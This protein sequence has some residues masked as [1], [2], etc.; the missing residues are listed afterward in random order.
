MSAALWF[1]VGVIAMQCG[2]WI[3][4]WLRKKQSAQ[5]N[6]YIRLQIMCRADAYASNYKS[7]GDALEARESLESFV[8]SYVVSE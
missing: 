7:G 3:G 4:G 5:R 2:T 6:Q 1:L 8:F